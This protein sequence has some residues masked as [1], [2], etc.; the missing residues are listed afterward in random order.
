M[1]RFTKGDE[2]RLPNGPYLDLYGEE[3]PLWDASK[4]GAPT[5]IVRGDQDRASLDPHAQKLFT[6][7]KCGLCHSVGDTGN[8]K[9]PL[10]DVGSRL[11]ADDIRMWITDSK[12]MTAKTKA[13]RKPAMKS[14]TLPKEDVDALVAYL[15]TPWKLN[16]L[17]PITATRLVMQIAPL[18]MYLAGLHW[19][20]CSTPSPSGRGLG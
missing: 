15:V 14:Y 12:T 10:D 4:I 3:A 17:V 18:A 7:L 5:L 1:F 9:G 19:R 16:E 11:S 2:L 6:D 8:K 13:T 20:E